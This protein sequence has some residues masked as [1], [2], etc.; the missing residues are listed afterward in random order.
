V[1]LCLSELGTRR[2]TAGSHIPGT[3]RSSAVTGGN[4]GAEICIQEEHGGYGR[5]RSDT[6]PTRLGTVR[7]QGSNGLPQSSAIGRRLR[8]RVTA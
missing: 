8:L 6:L 2:V 3:E 5:I 1:T 4:A 7:L